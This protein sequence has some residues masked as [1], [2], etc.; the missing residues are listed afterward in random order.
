MNGPTDKNALHSAYRQPIRDSLIRYEYRRLV[1]YKPIECSTRFLMLLIVPNDR[2][3]RRTLFVAYH[4]TPAAGHMG[5]YKTLYRL[6]IRFFWPSMRTFIEDAMRSCAHCIAANSRKRPASELQFSWPVDSPF[7]IVHV[8]LWVP[9][10]FEDYQGHSYL[11]NAMDDMTGFV[12][13]VPVTAVHAH[14]SC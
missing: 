13:S 12:V 6:R 5:R 2:E 11:M 9:G 7:C 1:Y 4:A 8:D 10:R 3:L 14:A